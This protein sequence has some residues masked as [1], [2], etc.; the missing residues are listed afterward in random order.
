MSSFPK[1]VLSILFI[2][3]AK[4]SDDPNP[5]GDSSSFFYGLSFGLTGNLFRHLNTSNA[6]YDG[7]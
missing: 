1:N 4:S 3:E 6:V 7:R 2:P 5:T